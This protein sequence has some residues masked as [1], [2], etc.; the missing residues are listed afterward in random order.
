MFEEIQ[1]GFLVTLALLEF[2]VI[3]LSFLAYSYISNQV[4][5]AHKDDPHYKRAPT[6]VW[7]NWLFVLMAML[8]LAIVIN[9]F[10]HAF[11]LIDIILTGLT[12]VA[13]LTVWKYYKQLNVFEEKQI[14]EDVAVNKTEELKKSVVDKIK[15][16]EV[17][18]AIVSEM[19]DYINKH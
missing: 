19:T 15:T 3:G 6:V 1:S 9:F 8:C 10:V 5:R 13:P 11:W 16:Y 7:F 2:T 12:V 4:I 14:P 17:D 18:D